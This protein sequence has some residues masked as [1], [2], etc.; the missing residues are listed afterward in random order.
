MYYVIKKQP[1]SPV[2]CFIG[3]QAPKY[4]AAKNSDNVI[5]EFMKDNKAIRKW[6]KK[7]EIVLL[8]EDKDFFTK[9][10][11]QFKAVEKTQQKLVDEAKE[12]LNQ[13]MDT[14][15]ETINTELDDFNEIKNLND[16]PCLLRSL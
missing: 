14:F 9:T 6:V 15:T 8:T 7:D 10:M 13:S 4:I 11:A 2:Q 5:F 1:Q 16:V 3:F 12:K